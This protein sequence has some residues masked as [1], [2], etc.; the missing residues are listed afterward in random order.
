MGQPAS[1]TTPTPL[2][3]QQLATQMAALQEAMHEIA[4]EVQALTAKAAAVADE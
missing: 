1:S 3:I 4:L 2:A